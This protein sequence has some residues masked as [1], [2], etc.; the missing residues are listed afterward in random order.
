MAKLHE[1]LGSLEDLF[2][3]ASE[4]VLPILKKAHKLIVS[5][6]PDVE[7][8]PRLGEKSISYGLGPKKMS[9]AYCYL[10]PFKTHVNLGFFHGSVID[11]KSEL[12]GTGAKMRHLKITSAKELDSP[13]VKAFLKA[14]LRERRA[15]LAR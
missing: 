2:G 15:A 3:A 8:V 9:E 1:S 12:S 5:L 4:E 6:H 11:P 7:I 13:Q 10:M 14:A